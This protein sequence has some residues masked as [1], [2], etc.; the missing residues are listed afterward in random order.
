MVVERF[1][2]Q[3]P[4]ILEQKMYIILVVYIFAVSV[5]DLTLFAG[6]FAYVIHQFQFTVN[7]TTHI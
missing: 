5:I 2:V 3:L 7:E 1:D 6:R 4:L